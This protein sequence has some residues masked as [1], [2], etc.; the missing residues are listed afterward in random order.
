[1]KNNKYFWENIQKLIDESKIVIDRPKG[2]KHPKFPKTYVYPLDYGYLTKTTSM[3]DD[4]IDCFCGSLTNK[5]V[6]GILCTIDIMKKDSE[7]KILI[8]C[9]KNE[10][11]TVYEHLNKFDFFRA[12]LLE[13]E[14]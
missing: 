11:N 3:D 12:I 2:S 7:I 13:K 10:I 1:M 5:I 9:T 6:V 4:G 8:D 14:D